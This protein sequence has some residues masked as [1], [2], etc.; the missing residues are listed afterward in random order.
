MTTVFKKVQ[1]KFCLYFLTR[2]QPRGWASLGSDSLPARGQLL[3]PSLRPPH[4]RPSALAGILVCTFLS[5]SGEAK[6]REA[7]SSLKGDQAPGPGLSWECWCWSGKGSWGRCCLTRSAETVCFH[8][9]APPCPPCL[10]LCPLHLT[11][12]PAKQHLGSKPPVLSPGTPRWREGEGAPHPSK[13][14]PSCCSS[15]SPSRLQPPLDLGTSHLPHGSLPGTPLGLFP[16]PQEIKVPTSHS[17]RASSGDFGARALA[18]RAQGRAA[19]WGLR[20]P[21]PGRFSRQG[22]GERT[23]I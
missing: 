20:A 19:G 10:S 6:A 16:F 23:G 18:P 5:V 14:R 9:S 3:A 8:G 12:L 11:S 15:S 2:R 21:R 4:P 1:T 22:L 13:R 17:F 7:G